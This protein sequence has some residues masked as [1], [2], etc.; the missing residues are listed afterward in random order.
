MK[1]L[2]NILE[3][4]ENIVDSAN[5]KYNSNMRENT[6]SADINHTENE[7]SFI[8]P[9]RI[10]S[11]TEREYKMLEIIDRQRIVRAVELTWQAGYTDY[12][13]CR[14]CLAKLE[15]YGYVATVRDMYGNKCYYL[16][17]RGLTEIGKP[18]A[19]TYEMSYTTNHELTV[20]RVATYLC[21][22]QGVNVFEMLFDSQMKPM[23]TRGEHRPDILL[24]DS[25]Y[26]I[27][28]NHKR[29]DQLEKNIRSNERFSQ[30]IWIVPRYKQ[31]VARNLEKAAKAVAADI[32]ILWLDDLETVIANANVHDNKIFGSTGE[33]KEPAAAPAIRTVM[34]KYK[35]NASRE[36]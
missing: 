8:D 22:T 23:F 36:I 18:G 4:R 29:Q 11:L 30:Q 5:E 32:S 9:Q 6:V 16:T 28:L 24:N 27:E 21:I 1:G 35:S 34:D 26:E 25:V 13:Y 3:N 17:G 2:K 12:T 20:A 19:H 7:N 31:K 15:K 14:K 10:I 33:Q